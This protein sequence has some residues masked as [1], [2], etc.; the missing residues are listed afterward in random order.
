M[1]VRTFRRWYWVHKWSS[2]ICTVFMLVL[3]LTGLP[4]VFGDELAVWLGEAVE[5]PER[6]DLS[7]PVTFDALIQDAQHR[8]P[9]EYVKFLVHDDDEAVWF[10]TM[11]E[12]LTSPENTVSFA[13]DSRTGAML[14]Q[15]A[16]DEGVVNFL[17]KL[18]VEMLAG[19][20]GTLFLGLM[21]L[22]FVASTVSGVVVYGPFM[23]KL[24]FGVVRR[25]GSVRL[26]C[27]DLHN[28]LGIVTAVWVFVVGLTGVINTL[29]RPL[30]AYW[31]MTDI[32]AMIAP[33]KDR[34]IPARIA[35]VDVALHAAKSAASDMNVRFIAFPGTPF[36][37]AHH[38][39]AF[40]RGQS[41][42]TSRL[43]TPLL[44]DAETG[45]VT[46]RGTLP[47]YLTALLLSQPLHFGDYGGLPLKLLWAVM[48]I[49]TIFILI[50][51]LYLWWKKRGMAEDALFA[52]AFPRLSAQ[53]M[54]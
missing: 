47:W 40:M 15:Q 7:A 48:D 24:P 13:Y 8:R 10:V 11:G 38:Y 35:S 39:M 52:E 21:G 34:P 33:F 37:G 51:G 43:L 49:L 12:S 42:L 36:A 20:P 2:L 5:P 41:P 50:S 17:F 4:L 28:L 27:L 53:G 25:E 54:M 14:H 19:L 26:A 23:H 18:H 32:G 45:D 46:A 22:L 16:A 3:C 6:V 44:I 9:Q 31:Q 30:L 29:D 1:T